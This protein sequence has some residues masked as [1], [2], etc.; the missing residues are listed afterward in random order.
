MPFLLLLASPW[1]SVRSA[2]SLPKRTVPVDLRATTT[3]A[4]DLNGNLT[5]DGTRTFIY[6]AENQLVTNFVANAWKTEHTYDG[7]GRKDGNRWSDSG[8]ASALARQIYGIE[9][10]GQRAVSSVEVFGSR[11]GSTFRGRGPPPTSDLGLRITLSDPAHFGAVNSEMTEIGTLFG[12]PRVFRC[13]PF[14]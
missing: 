13:N 1:F 7:F 14:T 9:V 5:N 2:A 3:F 4:Y 10:N 12:Q 11:V 8:E 6:D